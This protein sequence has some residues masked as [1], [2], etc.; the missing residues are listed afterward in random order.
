MRNDPIKLR[1]DAWNIVHV[2]VATLN[3]TDIL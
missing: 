1:S 2:R 3:L